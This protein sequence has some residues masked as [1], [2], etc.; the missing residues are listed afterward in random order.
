MIMSGDKK[1]LQEQ[2]EKRDKYLDDYEDSLGLPQIKKPANIEELNRYIT[3]STIELAALDKEEC[4]NI[5]YVL[6]Q[7]S[8]YLARCIN[9]DRARIIYIKN[10]IDQIV[11]RYYG[12]HTGSWEMQRNKAIAEDAAATQWQTQYIAE[13]QKI[14]RLHELSQ[15]LYDLSMAVNK[16][17]REK[18]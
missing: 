6:N 9:R 14:A 3:M 11:T 13:E 18:K 16:I 5:S 8:F 10:K 7:W 15:K 1:S 4:G 17:S 12:Q 2:I